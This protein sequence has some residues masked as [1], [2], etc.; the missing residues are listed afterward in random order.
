MRDTKYISKVLH[1]NEGK[2]VKC[3]NMVNALLIIT[4]RRIIYFVRNNMFLFCPSLRERSLLIKVK[5]PKINCYMYKI[6]NI[7]HVAV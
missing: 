5:I 7:P 2:V 4:A 1:K 6:C 3:I